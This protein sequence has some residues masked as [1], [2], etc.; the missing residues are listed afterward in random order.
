M[1]TDE[2]LMFALCVYLVFCEVIFLYET[3]TEALSMGEFQISLWP[4]AIPCSGHAG[5]YET[6]TKVSPLTELQI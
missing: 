1:L 5:L 6:L 2:P 3:P 4:G